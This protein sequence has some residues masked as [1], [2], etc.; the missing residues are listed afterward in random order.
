MA[1]LLLLLAS[2]S[3]SGASTVVDVCAFPTIAAAAQDTAQPWL[4]PS[5]S[6]PFGRIFHDGAWAAVAGPHAAR[7]SSGSDTHGVYKSIECSWTSGTVAL[8]TEVKHYPTSSATVYTLQFPQ[9]AA[10]TNVSVPGG[11]AS[12]HT[13]YGINTDSVAPFAEFPSFDLKKGRAANASWFTWVRPSSSGLE[14]K[15][16][17]TPIFVGGCFGTN[18]R[19]NV[20]NTQRGGLQYHDTQSNTV[21]E[22]RGFKFIK[23]LTGLTRLL[24]GI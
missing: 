10:R 15:G 14:S 11:P 12:Q 13:Q 9:G 20:A 23:N 17:F 4:L 5:A 21:Q 1:A 6:S 16:V 8:V 18:V 24:R 7:P 19:C 22:G 3:A 2:L